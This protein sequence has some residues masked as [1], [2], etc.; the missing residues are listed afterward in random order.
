M[1]TDDNLS[2]DCSSAPMQSGACSM[3]CSPSDPH[4]TPAEEAA[5]LLREYYKQS[6]KTNRPVSDSH[7]S[8][9][10]SRSATRSSF[11][12]TGSDNRV[13]PF[14][15][16]TKE[17][18]C[19][20]RSRIPARQYDIILGWPSNSRSDH[21]KRMR[22]IHDL[23]R[24]V[25]GPD[26]S[27][28][29]RYDG[30]GH[31]ITFAPT[32]SGKGVGVIIP[33]LLHYAGP[34][35]VIDPKGENL[36][37]TANYR[38]KELRQQI[39]VLD[40][41]HAVDSNWLT[42]HDIKRASLNPLDLCRL[43][44]HSIENDSQM[45]A[46][47]IAGEGGLGDDPFWDVSA[48]RVLSGVIAMEMEE[49]NR[50]SRPPLFSRIVDQF[51]AD[52]VVYDLAVLLDTR[53]PCRFVIQSISSFLS[54]TDVTRSGVLAMV[55]S[56]LSLFV[57]KSLQPHLNES[58]I[59][60][61]AITS[62][63]DYTLYIVIPPNKLQSHSVLLR[64]WVSV[65]LHAVM[66]RRY[67]PERRT[68]F[69]LDECANLGALDTLK[70]AVTLLRGYGLQVWMFF[71]DLSQISA[72]YPGDYQ[73]MVNN[74]GVLQAFGITRL[75]SAQQLSSIIGTFSP[76]SLLSLERGQQILSLYPGTVKA[77]NLFSYFSDDALKKFAG[78]NPLIRIRAP[79]PVRQASQ[80][81]RLRLW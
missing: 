36:A 7:D 6:S 56:Y 40:P 30:D 10:E 59:Q 5:F 54:L 81:S 28:A 4:L 43:S 67:L 29:I 72:L 46:Q 51:F 2:S 39:L 60:L 50:H 31:C 48:Q 44:S 57:A 32:G 34:V 74:C 69:M 79:L 47:L 42:E 55:Q 16:Q 53:K 45:I 8:I 41:F 35:V 22:D 24:G 80:G 14:A 61:D 52:D 33:N 71:Q 25:K 70:K 27:Y 21:N 68:L 20:S 18:A 64:I 3:A 9:A 17:S 38:K 37:V 73:T 62:G 23:N 1:P 26:L 77:A 66:E 76:R 13:A 58:T 15:S 12:T 65:L 75:S 78:T 49:A 11:G 63:E 19:S